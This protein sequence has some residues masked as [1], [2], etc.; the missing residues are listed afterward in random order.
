M[1]P[2]RVVGLSPPP[3]TLVTVSYP[4]GPDAQLPLCRGPAVTQQPRHEVEEL[5]DDIVL[6]VGVEYG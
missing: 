2:W 6:Y 1:G 3:T 5:T 4:V